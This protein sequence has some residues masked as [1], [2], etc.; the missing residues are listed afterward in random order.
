[1]SGNT[2]N[3]VQPTQQVQQSLVQPPLEQT[4]LLQQP[5]EQEP[6]DQMQEEKPISR[7]EPETIRNKR[8]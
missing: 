6:I 2:S 3:Q 1:M 7:P 4:K 8:S 5:L